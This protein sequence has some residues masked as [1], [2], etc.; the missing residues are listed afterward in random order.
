MSKTVTLEKL[1]E[2]VKNLKMHL[3]FEIEDPKT[4]YKELKNILLKGEFQK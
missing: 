2:R 1:Q 3:E 4:Y